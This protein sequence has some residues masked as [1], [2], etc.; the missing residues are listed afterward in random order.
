[1]H[2]AGEMLGACIYAE[3]YYASSRAVIE[4]VSQKFMTIQ[5][6]C[7]FF[8][9]F[10]LLFTKLAALV[11]LYMGRKSGYLMDESFIDPP[12]TLHVEAWKAFFFSL[13]CN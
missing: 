1:M 13:W 10:M 3:G 4:V 2:V 11:V 7:D 6:G 12:P 9:L 8:F 5:S